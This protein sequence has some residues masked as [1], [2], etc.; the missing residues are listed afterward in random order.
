MGEIALAVGARPPP[1]TL[2]RF[3]DLKHNQLREEKD[4]SISAYEAYQNDLFYLAKGMKALTQSPEQICVDAALANIPWETRTD[5]MDGIDAVL[6]SPMCNIPQPS[7]AELTQLKDILASLP[8]AV[9]NTRIDTAALCTLT[10]NTP[11][12]SLV[13]AS[14]TRLLPAV[15]HACA[16]VGMADHL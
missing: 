11:E 7:N 1:L 16:E 14:C 5:L 3:A 9:W 4:V 15:T 8:P 12:W 2:D 13:R 10:L 6:R